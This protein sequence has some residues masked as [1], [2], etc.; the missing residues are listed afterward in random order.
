MVVSESFLVSVPA[1]TANIGPGFDC[2]GAALTR[3]NR[4][5]FTLGSDSTPLHISL[6]GLDCDRIAT[7]Q[8]NLAYIAFCKC[9]ERL[10]QPVP[11]VQMEITLDV[12]LARGLGSSSTAIVGGILGA[13]A[14]AGFPLESAALAQLAID[15]EGHP[16]NVVPALLGGCRLATVNDQ[17]VSTLCDIP[18]HPEVVPV[19][20]V[21]AFEV[22]TAKARQ[23][24]PQHYSRTDAVYTLGHLGLLLRG[25]STAH[26]VW[27]RTAI[28]DRIH[29]P[30]RK[31][32]IPG[33]D[34]VV[35]AAIDAGAY[36]VTISGAGPTLLALG[37]ADKAAAI[38]QTMAQTWQQLGIE[39][40]DARPLKIDDQ[41]ATVT[42]IP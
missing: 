42:V 16:D 29:E 35:Q 30:Y 37:K 24:L 10:G 17:G 7:N 11:P 3:Y 34:T 21:P 23:V 22:S 19:V 2:L 6:T 14:L 1:T 8:S 38:A 15:I 9:F 27:L 33:Y 40:V 20:V 5:L 31:A 12:P 39:I 13:N 32:L 41:G 18:W 28:G 36:G 25:L 4:F 26:E